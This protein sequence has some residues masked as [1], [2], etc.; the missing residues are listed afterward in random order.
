MYLFPAIDLRG[1]NVVRLLKGDYDQ[2]TTYGSDPLAQAKIFEDAGSTWLHCVDLDGAKEGRM[3][4]LPQIESICKNTKLKVEI[5]GG[6]RTTETIDELLDAGV[7]R[8]ILGT[9]AMQNWDWFAGLMDNEKYHNRIVLGLDARK[10]KIAVAGW[11][12]TTETTALEVAQKVTDW[13]LAAIVFT[14]IA[15]DGT[16]AGPNVESTLEMAQATKVPIVASGGVGTLDH[17]RALKE[18][19]IQGSIVGRALYEGTMTID[20]AI[21]TLEN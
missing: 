11:L 5:G 18:L 2:Q 15:T 12:E 3:Y 16:L 20:E 9:A 8:V 17:L 4:H 7:E 1:G 14:D 19:P 21:Q 13:P 10:G 6:I